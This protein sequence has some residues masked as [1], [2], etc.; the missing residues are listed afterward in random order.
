MNS[1]RVPES[2]CPTCAKLLDS[3]TSVSDAST[4]EPGDLS[5][6]FYCATLLTFDDNLVLQALGEDAFAT[7]GEDLQRYLKQMRNRVLEARA[8]T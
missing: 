4:P 6:C 8:A 3:A 5:I 7:L 1:T 2:H